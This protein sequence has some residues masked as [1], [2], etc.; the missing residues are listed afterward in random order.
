LGESKLINFKQ[1]EIADKKWIDPLL[2]IV[3]SRACH[4]NFTNIF[5]W[6]ELYK[7]GVTK[8]ND[9]LL[10]K[11]RYG[12]TKYYFYPIGSGDV[13]Q[14]LEM[15]RQDA[16]ANDHPF[17]M[18]GI[19]AEDMKTLNELYPDKFAFTEMRDSYDYLYYIEK[20]VTLAG[21]KMHSKRNHVN[22][23]LREYKDWKFEII[24]AANLAE[25][26]E[27][28][29]QWCQENNC[30]DDEL[31]RKEKCVVQRCFN[32][33]DALGLEGGLLRVNG[34]VVAYTIG[35]KLNSDTYDIHIEKAFSRI[36]GAYQ[37]INREF[38]AYIHEKYPE[39]VYINREEDMGYEGL[40]KAKLSYKPDMMVEKYRALYLDS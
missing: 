17:L 7:Y 4:L 10:V 39:I 15:L 30:N 24:T 33:Y 18:L 40:R 9:F 34:E 38:A 12:K 5:T 21:N 29:D 23:F 6:S 32:N 20:L 27:M 37:M 35:E 2:Q 36:H 16:A 13:Q 1:V 22:R 19:S 28:N 3:D 26:R 8:V 14:V 11:G 31:L 25:C